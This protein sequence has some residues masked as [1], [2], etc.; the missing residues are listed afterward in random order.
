MR[1]VS[2]VDNVPGRC[3][4]EHGLS[5]WL[6]LDS[7]LRILF[8]TGQGGLFLENATALGIDVADAGMLV[9]SHGHYDHGGG[10]RAFFESNT[11]ARAYVRE[12][13]F[14]DHFSLKEEGLKYIGI[15]SD[16][17][18]GRL[19]FTTACE[20]IAPGVTL[21]SDVADEFPAPAGNARLFGPDRKRPDDFDHEQNMLIKDGGNSVLVAGCAHKGVLNILERGEEL[22]GGPLDYM[23]CGMHLMK[24]TAPGSVE[25][26]ASDLIGHAKCRFITM[27]CTG[28]ENF[29]LMKGVMGDRIS[30]LASGETVEL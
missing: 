25:S 16:V 13:A 1:I 18:G 10:L 2:L 3:P 30:Y 5:L 15:G 19:V 20:E 12:Q 4:G 9:I 14:E 6:E 26:L 23:V 21:F 17:P 8:D 24:C 11:K 28:F 29:S 7:G 27:H 22:N